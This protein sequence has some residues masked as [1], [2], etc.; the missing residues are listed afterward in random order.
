M[1]LFAVIGLDKPNAVALR[2][3]ARAA[4][5][6]FSRKHVGTTRIAGALWDADGNQC[7][8]LKIFEADSAEQLRELYADEPF[9]TAGV[10]ESVIVRE[11]RIA[12]YDNAFPTVPYPPA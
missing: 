12:Y 5:R 10:Y 7:G 2:D 1:P 9:F 8:T 11:W 4:H 6:D 3:K